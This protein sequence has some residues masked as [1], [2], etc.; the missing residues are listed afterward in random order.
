MKKENS[1]GIIPLIFSAGSWR[2]LLV[3]HHAGHWAFP[4]GHAD[5]GE[6]PQQTAERELLE[7]TGLTFERYLSPEP[8]SESYI[9]TFRGERIY[10]TVYYFLALVSGKIVIQKH[11]IKASQWLSLPEAF[12]QITFNEGKRVCQ[13]VMEFLKTVDDRGNPYVSS[14]LKT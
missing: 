13:Q 12:K 5:R 14:T 7:E 11:E 3:Q 4:K 6:S 1:Y 2:V 9:F 8:L 10:K